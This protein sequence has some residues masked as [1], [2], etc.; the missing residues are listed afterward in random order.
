MLLLLLCMES[1][2]Q[3]MYMNDDDDDDDDDDDNHNN[4]YHECS[5]LIIYLS[6]VCYANDFF[7]CFFLLSKTFLLSFQ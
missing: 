7:F 3:S 5:K 4:L 6:A 2:T 1:F